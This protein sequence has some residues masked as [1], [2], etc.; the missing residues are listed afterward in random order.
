LPVNEYLAEIDK[1]WHYYDRDYLKCHNE[2]LYQWFVAP[3]IPG[4]GKSIGNN[5]PSFRPWPDSKRKSGNHS[6][7]F[8]FIQRTE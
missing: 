5:Y 6:W 2:Y 8:Y 7:K 1:P 4:N 3:G